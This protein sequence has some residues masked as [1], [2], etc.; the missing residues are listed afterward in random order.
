MSIFFLFIFVFTYLDLLTYAKQTNHWE[1]KNEKKTENVINSDLTLG[2]KGGL[3]KQ[4]HW[5]KESGWKQLQTMRNTKL[6]AFPHCIHM[7]NH[8]CIQSHTH[9]SQR[10]RQHSCVSLCL[11]DVEEENESWREQL[12]GGGWMGLRR[13]DGSLW[14]ERITCARLLSCHILISHP[15]FIQPCRC[16][17]FHLCAAVVWCQV[18]TQKHTLLPKPPQQSACLMSVRNTRWRSGEGGVYCLCAFTFLLLFKRENWK[19]ENREINYL[20]YL[21]FEG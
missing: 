4:R 17:H 1:K 20:R 16:H 10:Q 18:H 7:H 5:Q 9:S 8:T 6:V 11:W 2:L 21:F 13:A 19:K 12:L 14:K 3:G 15:Q